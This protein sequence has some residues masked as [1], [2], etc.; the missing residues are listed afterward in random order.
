MNGKGSIALSGMY[1]STL[2]IWLLEDGESENIFV[3]YH[4]FTRLSNT[5]SLVKHPSYVFLY[6]FCYVNMYISLESK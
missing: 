6:I 1:L 2:F 4:L 5:S 3:P